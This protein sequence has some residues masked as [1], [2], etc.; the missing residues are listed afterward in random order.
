MGFKIIRQGVVLDIT[1]YLCVGNLQSNSYQI[2]ID[3]SFRILSTY[4]YPHFHF[5]EHNYLFIFIIQPFIESS[6]S[7]IQ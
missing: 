4:W 7:I 6:Y 1:M 5:C 3:G 2:E